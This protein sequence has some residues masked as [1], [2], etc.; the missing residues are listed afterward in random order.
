MSF[1]LLEVHR[2]QR[3]G[4]A[5]L[6]KYNRLVAAADASAHGSLAQQELGEFQQSWLADPAGTTAAAKAEKGNNHDKF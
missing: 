2:L 5:V 1:D 4:G 6:A 3:A